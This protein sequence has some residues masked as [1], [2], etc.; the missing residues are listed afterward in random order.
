MSSR[1]PHELSHDLS[2][3]IET[4]TLTPA[5]TTDLDSLKNSFALTLESL[6][7]RL[8]ATA[9]RRYGLVRE[10]AEDCIQD[11]WVRCER[12]SARLPTIESPEAWLVRTFDLCCK[13]KLRTKS[14]YSINL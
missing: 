7:P 14:N 2:S 10:D 4:S 5:S 9:K 6:R 11:A 1:H 12:H 8:I 13:D 3:S